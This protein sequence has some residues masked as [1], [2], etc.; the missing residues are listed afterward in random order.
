MGL[1]Y[2][3]NLYFPAK[4]LGSVLRALSQMAPSA[5]GSGMVIHRPRQ[6]E[7]VVPFTSRWKNEPVALLEAGGEIELE[8]VLRFAT[9][10]AIR[11]AWTHK[12][13]VVIDGREYAEIGYIYLTIRLGCLYSEFSFTAATSGMSRLFVSSAS[14]RG[15]FQELLAEC[16]GV[17]SWL[18]Q[19]TFEFYSLEDP[20]RTFFPELKPV[21]NEDR[22]TRESVD[23]LTIALCEGLGRPLPEACLPPH[24]KTQE[25]VGM[26]RGIKE[27]KAFD[28][29]PILAD[30]LEEAGCNNADILGHCRGPGPH[31][32]GCW[33]VDLLWRRGENRP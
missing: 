21:A 12:P 22:T 18:D 23:C 26:A 20:S 9:D 6:E 14:I 4:Q 10:E 17:A 27:D 13:I 1:D 5:S 16:G 11:Q 32:R 19:E 24:W 31:V 7:V 3:I 30:A 29:L 33:V 8:T 15:R 28:R 2:S 25:I